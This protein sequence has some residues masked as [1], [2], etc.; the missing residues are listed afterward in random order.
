MFSIVTLDPKFHF[1][2]RLLNLIVNDLVIDYNLEAG[3]IGRKCNGD[4]VELHG[5]RSLHICARKCSRSPYPFFGFGNNCKLYTECTCVCYSDSEMTS[6]GPRC[7]HGT[8]NT[9]N[10]NLYNFIDGKSVS[11]YLMIRIFYIII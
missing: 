6:D 5:V 7:I 9:D 2:S 10:R 8:S 3:N 1:E 4:E 11:K